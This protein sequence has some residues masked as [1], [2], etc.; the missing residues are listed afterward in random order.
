MAKD[1]GIHLNADGTAL[2]VVNGSEI[3][4][5]RPTLGEY[6]DLIDQVDADRLDMI[7]IFDRL[8]GIGKDLSQLRTVDDPEQVEDKRRQLKT[9]RQT[10]RDITARFLTAVAKTL[11]SGDI[12]LLDDP[13]R[14]PVWRSDPTVKDRLI[15]HW[16]AAPFPG[17]AA[18]PT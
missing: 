3:K 6:G 9:E 17:S 1:E 11:G 12:A 13:D 15:A 4:L 2:I 7:V 16:E 10:V 5:R 18:A 8:S 14:A